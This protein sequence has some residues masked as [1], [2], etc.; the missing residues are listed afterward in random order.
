T[1]GWKPTK[2]NHTQATVVNQCASCHSGAYPP[3]DGKPAAHTP[4]Q[5]VGTLAGLNC[6]SC[7]KAGY[8]S[9]TPARVHA[10]VSVSNQCASCH[11][12]I[13]PN[14][15]IHAGQ[16]VCESCHNSTSSWNTAKVDHSAFTAA[17]NCASC[18]NGSAATGKPGVHIPVGATNC[19]ACHGTSGWKPTKW[20]HTQTN[21]VNQCASCHSGAFPPADGKTATH[22]PYQLVGTLAGLNCDSC[23]KAGYSSWTPARLHAS[24]SVS[25]QCASCHLAIRPVTTIHVGQTLCESCHKS[26][27][28]WTGARVDHS[29]FTVATNCSSCHNGSS[30]TGKPAVHIPVVATNCIACHGTTAWKPTKWNHTQSTVVNQ[31]ASCHNGAYPPADGKPATHTPYQ[32]VGTLAGLNCDSC[33]KAGFASWTPARL[34]ASVSVS[35]QCASCHLAIRPVTTIHLG[36]TLCENCHKSTSTWTGARVDHATFTVATNC[37]SCHN[38]SAATG[39]PA[40][41]IPVGATNCIACHGTTAWKPTKWNHTQLP[42]LDCASCHNGAYPPADGRPAQHIPY[43]SL[44]GV[45]IANCSTC[46]RSGYASWSGA[47]LHTS[48]AVTGQCKTCHSGSYTSQ[49]AVA[50]PSNHIPESQLLN[51]AAMDCVSCH[52]TTTSWSPKMNHNASLGSGAG[53]CKSCHATGTNYSGGMERMALTHRT[54]T[55]VPTDCSQSGCHRPLGTKG[56]AYSKWD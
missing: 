35:N 56:A 7:H 41:H 16:T 42:V 21:V 37:S 52:T 36:Q 19:I 43:Q 31:C 28:T 53:W 18:H 38:G 55:P 25:S 5:L 27:S 10:S 46:H 4:Y 32:L 8:S 34:H 6:D 23:H 33:H 22:T 54:T 17:T 15:A 24:V 14:T 48:V 12:A 44:T 26:T 29:T 47:R 40:V 1:S 3:A 9:W 11:A 45:V 30:A 13:K 49:G 20:N 51:G 2:W 39:R 50:K